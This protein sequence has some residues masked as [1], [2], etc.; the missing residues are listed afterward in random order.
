MSR[1]ALA[2]AIVLLATAP[3]LR[4]DERGILVDDFEHGLR[5]RWREKRYSIP[6]AHISSRTCPSV[7]SSRLESIPARWLA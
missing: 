5:D 1:T 3:L 4:A 6:S 2:V 7:R